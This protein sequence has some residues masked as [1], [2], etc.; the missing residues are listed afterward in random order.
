[1]TSDNMLLSTLQE[2]FQALRVVEINKDEL[3]EVHLPTIRLM[4]PAL[5][6]LMIKEFI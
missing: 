5:L 1:M 2:K 4:K 6:T 3:I